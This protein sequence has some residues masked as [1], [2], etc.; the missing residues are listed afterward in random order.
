MVKIMPATKKI[1]ESLVP[2]EAQKDDYEY[3]SKTMDKIV[4]PQGYAL[5]R[6]DESVVGIIGH[7]DVWEGRA[8]IWCLVDKSMIGHESIL[9]FRF[10]KNYF[11]ALIKDGMRRLETSVR[12]GH[13]EGKRLME[14]LGFKLEGIMKSFDPWG[15]DSY[16]YARAI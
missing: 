2:Q 8:I 6:E 7:V 5:I 12:L 14:M 9:L 15:N 1:Y 3:L 4:D 13:A 16:L 11:D 10:A